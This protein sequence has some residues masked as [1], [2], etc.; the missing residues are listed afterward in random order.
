MI[1]RSCWIGDWKKML[2][3]WVSASLCD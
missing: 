3:E 1:T 2:L